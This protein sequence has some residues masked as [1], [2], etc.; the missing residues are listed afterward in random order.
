MSPHPSQ[1][2]RKDPVWL[3]YPG[4]AWVPGPRWGLEVPEILDFPDAPW[5][6]H[7]S[8]MLGPP[9]PHPSQSGRKDPV[10][11]GYP[12]PAWV[13]ERLW[14]LDFPDAPWHHHRN[15]MLG[16]SA[17]HPSQSGRK[18]PVQPGYPGAAWVP[19]SSLG[20]RVQPGYPGA[21][22]SAAVALVVGWASAAPGS[23]FRRDG[24]RLYQRRV[25][26]FRGI[27]RRCRRRCFL[28]RPYWRFRGSHHRRL[29]R[30]S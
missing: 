4:P 21:R 29:R 6:H 8:G 30:G 26:H 16:P 9:G 5:H 1:S 18:D 15:G 3:G 14:G 24:S 11:L 28:R 12:R 19:G 17:P 13:P 22:R 20:T 27:R 2:G 23:R 25:R 10:W 7:R